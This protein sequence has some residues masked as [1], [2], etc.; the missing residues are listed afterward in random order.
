MMERRRLLERE[1]IRLAPEL[2]R[3]GTTAADDVLDAAAA[4]WTA[5]RIAAG[6]HHT[7]PERPEQIEG[8]AVAIHV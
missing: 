2:P 5:R 7:V 3:I 8:R 1:G 6:R 4:A